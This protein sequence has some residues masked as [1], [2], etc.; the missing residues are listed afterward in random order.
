MTRRRRRTWLAA[1]LTLTAAVLAVSCDDDA[2]T[3]ENGKRRPDPIVGDIVIPA[4][5]AGQ[6]QAVITFRECGSDDIVCVEDVVGVICATDTLVLEV[7]PILNGCDGLIDDDR[8]DAG[9]EHVF[10]AGSCEVTISLMLNLDREGD[11]VT[12]TGVWTAE[13]TGS[14][15]LEYPAGCET[16]EIT[17]T[18]LDTSPGPCVPVG[19]S[20]LDGIA[21]RARLFVAE[22]RVR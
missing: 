20:L 3:V 5:W 21:A 10:V 17:A 13:R 11:T 7:S 16:V 14:C 2:T 1:V 19:T 22:G 4:S 15:T 12:G 6:W 18:R 9:C 8:I